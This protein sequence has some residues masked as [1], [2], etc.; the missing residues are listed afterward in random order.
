MPKVRRNQSGSSLGHHSG[1]GWLER[2]CGEGISW[3][4]PSGRKQVIWAVLGSVNRG[5]GCWNVRLAWQLSG[6][7][8]A[9][10]SWLNATILFGVAMTY[11]VSLLAEVKA[12]SQSVAK[13]VMPSAADW[14]TDRSMRWCLALR[15]ICSCKAVVAVW[16]WR[17]TEKLTIWRQWIQKFTRRSYVTPRVHSVSTVTRV[18]GLFPT[19]FSVTSL[20]KLYALAQIFSSS[21]WGCNI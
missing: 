13:Q 18:S 12:H 2:V 19:W 10:S 5:D 9:M 7:I 14:G 16:Y 11:Y 1:H 6:S 4:F 20:K 17:W 15:C 8:M 21:D 3:S